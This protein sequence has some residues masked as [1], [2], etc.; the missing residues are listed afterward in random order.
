MVEIT[1]QGTSVREFASLLWVQHALCFLHHTQ[2]CSTATL[3]HVLH[4]LITVKLT[5]LITL[6]YKFIFM[7]ILVLALPADVQFCVFFSV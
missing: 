6:M 1:V 3:P 2:H 7:F 4:S 5:S